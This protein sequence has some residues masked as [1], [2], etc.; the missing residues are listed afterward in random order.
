[1]SSNPEWYLKKKNNTEYG[2]VSLDEL[3]LWAQQCRIVAGNQASQDQENWV[4]VESI[5]ALEMDW[6]AQRRDG[7]QYGPFPLNA[8]PALV[9]HHVLPEDAT[10]THRNSGETLRMQEALAKRSERPPAPSPTATKPTQQPEQNADEPVTT[11]DEQSL[12]DPKIAK[13]P[14]K[15]EAEVALLHQEIKVLKKQIKALLQTEQEHKQAAEEQS[16]RADNELDALREELDN[17]KTQ[18]AR[19]RQRDQEEQQALADKIDELQE[20]LAREQATNQK[21]LAHE[22]QHEDIIAELRQQV[23]FMKKNMA[24]LNAQLLSTRETSTQR[25][26]LLAGAWVVVTF[27]TAALIVLLLSR[28]CRTAPDTRR[29]SITDTPVATQTETLPPIAD[30]RQETA[31]APDRNTQTADAVVPLPVITIEGIHI[32]SQNRNG[33]SLRFA[34]GIFS[35]L[36]TL[37]G[38]GRQ[39]LDALARQLPRN[40][41][42]WELVIEGHTDDIPLRS[43]ARFA[44]N[45]ALAMARAVAV[46]Q[47][48]KQRAGFPDGTITAR[49]GTTAPYPNDSTDNRT[50]NRTVTIQ[51]KRR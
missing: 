15:T 16:R 18:E 14:A 48:M 47:H 34:E 6:F 33:L 22:T 37:S 35:A 42:G 2:P 43:T 17:L 50:R 27:V 23:A 10:L 20:A 49:P 8:V 45:E 44:N 31:A 1:M 39:L 21:T 4:P 7:K 12:S 40:L 19:Q 30:R 38:E 41:T 46:A 28:G 5:P 24:A 25:A 32:V 9:E 26:K 29:E 3:A 11:Q 36:D 51:L 13:A